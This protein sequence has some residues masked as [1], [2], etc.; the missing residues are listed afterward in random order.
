MSPRPGFIRDLGFL[1]GRA[2]I[3]AHPAD[4]YAPDFSISRR[5]WSHAAASNRALPWLVPAECTAGKC[6]FRAGIG[7]LRAFA[8]PLFHGMDPLVRAGRRSALS[9]TG[10]GTVI[11]SDEEAAFADPAKAGEVCSQFLGEDPGDLLIA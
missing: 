8:A 11:G 7:A 6:L 5:Y 4:G 2:D 9:P 1:A 10:P 3:Q